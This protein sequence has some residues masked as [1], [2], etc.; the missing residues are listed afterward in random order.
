[1]KAV[2]GITLLVGF[3]GRCSDQ[4]LHI[5]WYEPWWH[6]GPSGHSADAGTPDAAVE[7]QDAAAPVGD[8]GA[9]HDAGDAS[10]PPMAADA[11][12]PDASVGGGAA[13][14]PDASQPPPAAD[15]AMPD[16]GPSGTGKACAGPPGLYDDGACTHLSDGVRP[17]RPNYELWSDGAKKER[18]IY[19]PAG[20]QIDTSNPNRWSFPVGTRIYK[21]FELAGARVETRLL[22]KNAAAASIDSWTTVS[23]EWSADQSTATAADAAG[24]SDLLGTGHDIPS[25][26]QCRS[27]HTMAGADAVNG[28]GAIQL[29]HD[30]DADGGF[31]LQSLLD[32]GSLVNVSGGTPNVSVEGSHIPGDAAAQAALGYLHGNCGNCHGGT[33]PKANLTLWSTVMTE[34][35][36][37]A[38]ALKSAACQ[39]LTRWTGRHN[40]DGDP[41]LLRIAP[42]H[43]AVSGVIGRMSVRVVNEQMPPI[44][45][46][47]VDTQGIATV[48]AFIDALD[49]SVCD[50]TPPTCPAPSVAGAGGASAS[51]AGGAGGAGGASATSMTSLTTA[52]AGGS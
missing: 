44:G 35:L 29:N 49:P 43:S 22:Q 30:A 26:A 28:F 39:C 42:G 34:Q 18:F 51:G 47:L 7:G 3:F 17:Y 19:L 46:S 5:P 24:V 45:T 52:G 25:Q 36:D 21:T 11:A 16:G 14:G 4:E 20:S 2:L 27:C 8:G 40:P 41:Y 50:A 9:T 32:E 48:A 38:A 33:A 1:M 10:S 6:H 12:L 13:G 31:T 37:D 15:G 23:Y